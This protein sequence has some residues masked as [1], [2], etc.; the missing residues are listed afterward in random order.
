MDYRNSQTI[1][2][3][4]SPYYFQLTLWNWISLGN[5]IFLNMKSLLDDK[6]E[7]INCAWINFWP[8]A[9]NKC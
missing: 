9:N 7:G 2:S 8:R 1:N 4:I 6:M 5:I 3:N